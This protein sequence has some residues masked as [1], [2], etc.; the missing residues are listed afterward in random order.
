MNFSGSN[1]SSPTRTKTESMT[2]P[3]PPSS[4]SRPESVINRYRIETGDDGGGTGIK[5]AG[6]FISANCNVILLIMAG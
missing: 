2:G 6:V 1:D 5:I 3:R 4:S